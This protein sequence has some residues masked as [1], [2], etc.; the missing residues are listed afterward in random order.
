M[1]ELRGQL[2][3]LPPGAVLR[4]VAR[5]PAAPIDLP[6]WCGL[7]GHTLLAA[8]HPHYLIQR[9]RDPS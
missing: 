6:A 1:L 9:K 7:V 3:A 2:R 8:N 5:D 4:V